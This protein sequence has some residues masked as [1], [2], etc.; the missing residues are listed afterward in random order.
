[1]PGPIALDQ[2]FHAVAIANVKL[3]MR[4]AGPQFRL[5]ALHR[6]GGGC[7]GAEEHASHVV[8]DSNDVKTELGKVKRGFRSDQASGARR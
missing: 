3:V 7:A 5:K 6:P 1:M 2:P 8:V 4:I